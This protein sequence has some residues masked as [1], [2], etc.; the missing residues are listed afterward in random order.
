MMK[1][2]YVVR[3]CKAEGQEPDARLTELGTQQAENLAKFLIDKDIDCIISS[4]YE[5]AFR[6][7]APLA[8]QIGIKVVLDDR[9]TER[10]LS[11]RNQPDWRNMLRKTFDDPDL[12]YEGGESS[13]SAMSRAISVVMEVLNSE[14]KNIVLVSHGNLISLMLKHFD[15][16]IGF[17]DWESLSNP[18][19]YHLSFSEYKQPAV[20]RIW[21]EGTSPDLF[22]S[23]E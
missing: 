23:G 9:L 15:D 2:V 19:V 21:T 7:I 14:G 3:H 17:K 10:I 4:P 12:C 1:N 6:T 13:S 5:R 20:H 16:R 11:S 18:D 8:E 22:I